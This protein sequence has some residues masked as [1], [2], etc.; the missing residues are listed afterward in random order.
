MATNGTVKARERRAVILAT[1][2]RDGS[3][4]LDRVAAE[5]GVSA[6]T[7]RRDLDGLEAEGLLRRVRGGAVLF[8]G[9]QPFG[10]RQAVR[11]RAKEAIAAKAMALIPSSGS[12]ALDASSTAGT[13]GRSIGSRSGLTVA[14]NSHDNFTRLR[15][16]QGVTPV[17]VGGEAEET[18]GSFVGLLACQAASSMLYERLFTSA[19]AVDA[20][21]GTSEVSLAESQVKRAFAERAQEV[22]LCVDSSKLGHQ[23]VALGF[24]F[25][26]ISVMITELAPTDRRLA[27]YRNLVEIR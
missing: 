17:L 1:L 10:E 18:T 6:M 16:A 2:R 12:I 8:A 5:L 14:T 21:H 20:E 19:S 4:Q 23:S 3:V 25:D 24:G 27:P 7:V 11:L 9:P 26:E 13:I 15:S 22:I